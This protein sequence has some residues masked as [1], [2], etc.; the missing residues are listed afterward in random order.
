MR[1]TSEN[2][3]LSPPRKKIENA[4]SRLDCTDFRISQREIEEK[5]QHGSLF[6]FEVHPVLV[7]GFLGEAQD[8]VEDVLLDARLP[9]SVPLPSAG[10]LHL[11]PEHQLRLFS[12]DLWD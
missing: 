2:F 11:I 4:S 1:Q 5:R 7:P 3:L 10:N 8:P 6:S 12:H 9:A